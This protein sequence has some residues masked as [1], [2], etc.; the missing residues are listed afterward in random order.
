MKKVVC[1]VLYKVTLP[2]RYKEHGLVL[3]NVGVFADENLAKVALRTQESVLNETKLRLGIL[4]ISDGGIEEIFV[5]ET[6]MATAQQPKV[7]ESIEEFAQRVQLKNYASIRGQSALEKHI[8]DAQNF[9]LTNNTES[10][11]V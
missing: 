10:E 6:R 2:V 5:P 9:V 4:Y 11:S 1:N 3:H 7:I 8:K